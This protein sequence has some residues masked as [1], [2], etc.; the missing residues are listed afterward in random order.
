MSPI[1]ITILVIAIIITIVVVRGR[2]QRNTM[3]NSLQSWHEFY[4]KYFGITVDF[5]DVHVPANPGDFDRIIFIPE[6]LKM[7]DVLRAMSKLFKWWTYAA[8]DD[9]DEVVTGN[10]RTSAKAYAIRC[11]ERVEA[12]EELKNLSA[13]DLK[14][15]GINCMTFLERAV[16]G[17]KY[18]VETRR[19]LDIVNWTLCAGSRGADGYVLYMGFNPDYDEVRVRCYRPDGS[20]GIMRARQVVS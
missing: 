18:F 14:A 16:Y 6:G 20:D 15:K 3:D 9:L 12:D 1:W 5:S 4:Q 13:N 8:N 7:N 10:V 17:I 2:S 11:R 19:H